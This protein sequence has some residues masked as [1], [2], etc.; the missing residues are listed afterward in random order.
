LALHKLLQE[1]ASTCIQNSKYKIK[2]HDIYVIHG[3]FSHVAALKRNPIKEL[4]GGDL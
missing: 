4:L 2:Q 1:G 3:K